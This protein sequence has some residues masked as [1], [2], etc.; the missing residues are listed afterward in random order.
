MLCTVHEFIS[1]CSR[2]ELGLGFALPCFWPRCRLTTQISVHHCLLRVHHCSSHR[3][4]LQLSPLEA[5]VLHS[6]SLSDT[7]VPG[8]NSHISFG[9]IVRQTGRPNWTLNR[10]GCIYQRVDQQHKCGQYGEHKCSTCSSTY[11]VPAS[12]GTPPIRMDS[13]EGP[14]DTRAR[15]S[16]RNEPRAR[17]GADEADDGWQNSEESQAAADGGLWRAYG[18]VGVGAFSLRTCRMACAHM[19]RLPS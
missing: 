13:Q 3:A 15:S 10:L 4:R 6:N 9:V 19:C 17:D 16:R 5:L 14:V 2:R 12:V 8:Q 1:R 18:P 7:S 11:K